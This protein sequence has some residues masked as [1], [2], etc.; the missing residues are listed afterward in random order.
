MKT[1]YI[2]A[3]EKISSI[4]NRVEKSSAKKINL[5]VPR[6]SL[7]LQSQTNFKLF[8]KRAQNAGKEVVIISNDPLMKQNMSEP[9]KSAKNLLTPE[10]FKDKAVVLKRSF[11]SKLSIG[12]LTAACL[13]V[14]FLGGYFVLP[15]ATIELIPQTEN[16]NADLSLIIN[17]NSDKPDLLANQIPGRLISADKK[18]VKRVAVEQTISQISKSQGEIIVYNTR[19]QNQ[20]LIPETRFLSA[21]NK[22]F[23]SLERHIIPAK[24]QK[25]IKVVAACPNPSDLVAQNMKK[26]GLS[27]DNDNPE[28]YNIG[29]SE[30]SL[31][32]CKEYKMACYKTVYGRSQKPMS[33]GQ[34]SVKKIVT[35][36][37]IDQAKTELRQDLL[38]QLQTQI[39]QQLSPGEKIFIQASNLKIIEQNVSVEPGQEADAFNIS[40]TGSL[41]TLAFAEKDL[42]DLLLAKLGS[43]IE[44]DQIIKQHSLS[45][46]NVNV[47]ALANY[48]KMSI[49]LSAKAQVLSNVNEMDL[50]NKLIGKNEAEI[51]NIL[52][53]QSKITG[54]VVKLWPFWV[55]Q[56]P[57]SK[58]KIELKIKT[59]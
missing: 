7:L 29:P 55:K 40:L 57:R 31:P 45:I 13:V 54:S 51:K 50:K 48:D 30:F 59:N 22:L 2:E 17:Q 49:D 34:V 20:V 38:A 12:V 25:T 32:A 18:V 4:L 43:E 28:D 3:D 1:I 27:C 41:K 37:A 19:S 11:S 53:N 46:E 8:K 23:Y 52:S 58:E 44:N 16:I 21:N 47:Y 9:N 5:I 56:V 6:D 39:Q 26:M 33:G 35:Q 14:I 36:E 42:N 10:F 24:G 15:R